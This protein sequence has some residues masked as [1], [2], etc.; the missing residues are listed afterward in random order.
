MYLLLFIQVSI[1]GNIGCGK[2]T[3]LEYFKSSKVVEVI[4]LILSVMHQS[5]VATAPHP[6]VRVGMARLMCRAM[7]F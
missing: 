1:E 4:L 7:N 2:T 3:L 6:W 5:F